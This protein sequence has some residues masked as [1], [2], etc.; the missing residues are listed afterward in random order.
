[1][2]NR[3]TFTAVCIAMIILG[4]TTVSLDMDK[5]YAQVIG[6]LYL[7][8]LI[9][10]FIWILALLAMRTKHTITNQKHAAADNLRELKDSSG[11]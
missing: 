3:K 7:I 8:A 9:L 4:T 6:F 11:K 2:G 10:F 1:M 5:R